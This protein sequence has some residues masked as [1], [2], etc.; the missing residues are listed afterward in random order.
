MNEDGQ[1]KYGHEWIN[2]Q[3]EYYKIPIVS[4]GVYKIS[5]DQMIAAGMNEED[6]KGS[7]FALIH[8]GDQV[9]IYTSSEDQFT[10]DDFI[11]FYGKQNRGELDAYLYK[12]PESDQLNPFYSLYTDENA[13]YLVINPSTGNQRIKEIELSFE[14]DNLPPLEK[15][16][17]HREER[18]FKDAHFKPTHNGRDFIRY[19]SYDTGEGYGS[20][21]E[22]TTFIQFSLDHIYRQGSRPTINARYATTA[23]THFVE[24][25][26]GDLVLDKHIHSGYSIRDFSFTFNAEH[27]SQDLTV[28]V[29]GLTGDRDRHT[30]AHMSITYPR[31]FDFDQADV[32]SFE[33]TASFIPRYL[34]IN[35][36]KHDQKPV[37]LWDVANDQLFKP[38]VENGIVKVVLPSSTKTR[39][40]VLLNTS[41]SGVKDIPNL[42]KIRIDSQVFNPEDFIIITNERLRQSDQGIDWVEEYA[43]YRATEVGGGH[44]ATII[45]V[46]DLYESFGYGINGHSIA[47]K[48]Y[49]NYL[50]DSGHKPNTV[51]IIGKGL[52]YPS[53]RQK[54]NNNGRLACFVPTYGAPGGDNLLTASGF[55]SIPQVPIGRLAVQSAEEIKNYLDKVKSFEAPM[56]YTNESE[57][58]WRKRV[59]HLSGGSADI[60]E[61]L[62]GYLNDMED[63]IRS[64]YFGG[65]VF[66][67]RKTTADLLQ[68][69]QTNEIIERI[70]EGVSLIT[71]FGHAAVGTFDFSLEDPSRYDNEGKNP[72]ILSLGCHSGNVHTESFGLSE[73]FVLEPGKGAVAFIASSGTAYI[74]PQ[75]RS[76]ISFYENIGD[77]LDELNIGQMVQKSL[78][79][80][81]DQTDIETVTLAEQLTIH[82]DPLLRFKMSKGPDYTIRYKSI[83]VNPG[84]VN[85]TQDSF[86]VSFDL[87]NRGSYR[88]EKIELL[89][90]HLK[91]NGE[92]IYRQNLLTDAPSFSSPISITLPNPGVSA[93]GE[94]QIQVTI[95]PDNTSSEYP[96]DLGEANNQIIAPDGRNSYSFYI[97]DN[98]AHPIY[99]PEFGILNGD[100][101]NVHASSHNGLIPLGEYLFEIDTTEQFDSPLLAQEKLGS[102]NS[103]VIW[104]PDVVHLDNTVYY[105]RLRPFGV[106]DD[107]KAWVGSSFVF[108]PG[109][110]E[111][112]NQS[113]YYQWNKNDYERVFMDQSSRALMFGNRSWDIRV[114]NELFDPQDYWVFINGI[115]WASLNP[116]QLAPVMS[117]FIWHPRDV[118]FKNNGRDYGSLSF[119]S[120]AFLYRMN[121][122]ADRKNLIDLLNAAP[123]G[124]RIF[125]H[126]VLRDDESSL[127]IEDWQNDKSRIGVDLFEEMKSYGAT[128]FE[129]LKERGT[130]PYTYIFDKG[131]GPVAEDIAN[132]M[133]ET[134]DLSS[135]GRS[136]WEDGY[137]I[138]KEIGPVKRF[139]RLEWA[140]AKESTDQTTTIILGKK[141][142]GTIDTL[143]K[144]VDDYSVNLTFIHPEEYPVIQLVYQVKD[145]EQKS[146]ANLDWWRVYYQDLPDVTFD[147][148]SSVPDI[149]DTLLSGEELK[150]SYGVKNISEEEIGSF[151]IKYTLTDENNEE[152][153]F[154]S[155]AESLGGESSQA[156]LWRLNEILPEGQYKLTVEINEQQSP[157]ERSYKNNIGIL[158]FFVKSDKRD[159]VLEIKVN[160]EKL[161]ENN[162]IGSDSRFEVLLKHP[163]SPILLEDPSL[164]EITLVYPSEK[165]VTFESNEVEFFPAISAL[166]NEARALFTPLLDEIG[167]Y[168]L[169]VRVED[170]QNSTF[171]RIDKEIHFYVNDQDV[172]RS[173]QIFPNPARNFVQIDI[174]LI[175]AELPED[176]A[177]HIFDSK[178]KKIGTVSRL[179]FQDIGTAP[180]IRSHLW[181]ASDAAGMDL[182]SGVYLLKVDGKKAEA[183]VK[184]SKKLIIVR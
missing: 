173:V 114:K 149:P 58:L 87:L 106:D 105:W 90:A 20:P 120:D 176:F 32:F 52:E 99:P 156:I 4:D 151:K 116:R 153:I 77:Q 118:L 168:T 167:R 137:T 89:V 91:P 130:V 125:I 25:K 139:M 147:L 121:T 163:S 40:L 15:F 136:Y 39:Q 107:E 53:F 69:S 41:S 84:V 138:S 76:G 64:N 92:V 127:H 31:T 180:N 86:L 131:I 46:D 6:L 177:I 135:V 3:L 119:S 170:R 126:T 37:L 80:M 1:K 70:N 57:L 24:T 43:N 33:L 51:F 148:L 60:Q 22:N 146:A 67:F 100:I 5:F 49:I 85:S 68:S 117:V 157:Q 14:A 110:R 56:D 95:D 169:E 55:E 38:V 152:R 122:P 19:S 30:I 13:Y 155:D 166:E 134:I 18:I 88:Q 159:P 83:G 62:F 93:I 142:D 184:L 8:F 158:Q 96:A 111:G 72:I 42:N 29:E 103:S 143:R 183:N 2:D 101:I 26:I 112:W 82:G 115:P 178:G 174:E 79:Q 12:D 10:K 165:K 145:A 104:E 35:N 109:E 124:S 17:M 23:S 50:L 74:N 179:A 162:L 160:D 81:K 27:L 128:K 108:A 16:Y 54:E 164:F 140:E 94:N 123:K 73:D 181:R 75:Y 45:N 36:F 161:E 34:E 47:V 154:Y 66:T 44:K 28:E 133:Y 102:Q 144:V 129:L 9:P 150:L 182:A 172:I 175:G 61:L 98:S 21:V 171:S 71:F 7:H 97:L 11:L 48:N 113:H 141:V 65:D 132:N 78:L 59:L 63:I